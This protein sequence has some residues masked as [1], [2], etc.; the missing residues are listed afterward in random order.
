MLRLEPRGRK[1]KCVQR[2]TAAGWTT[3]SL[4]E[5]CKRDYFRAKTTNQMIKNVNKRGPTE[6]GSKYYKQQQETFVFRVSQEAVQ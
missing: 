5:S 2:E 3:S 4:G 6:S 1:Q